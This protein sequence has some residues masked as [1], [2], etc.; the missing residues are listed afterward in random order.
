MSSI[1]ALGAYNSTIAELNKQTTQTITLKDKL[2]KTNTSTATD[3]ELMQVC[4]DFE[5]YL[6]EQVFKSMKKMVPESEDDQNEY[7]QYFGDNLYQEYAKNMS[8]AG[9]LGIA[10]MLYESMKRQ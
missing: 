10:Q 6:A 9:E 7:M 2:D 4:K 1:D 5:A 8:D 3:D